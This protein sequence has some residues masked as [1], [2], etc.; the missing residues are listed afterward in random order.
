MARRAAVATAVMTA[1]LA[2]GPVRAAC[3]TAPE[4]AAAQVRDMQSRLMVATLRCRAGGLDVTA[5]YN[6]F[7]QA[8]RSRLEGANMTLKAHFWVDGP[9]E[10]QRAYDRFTTALANAYGAGDTGAESCAEAAAQA[11][12]AAALEGGPEV[13]EAFAA[14]HAGPPALDA[15]GAGNAVIAAR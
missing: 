10:G 14:R 12:E 11:T 5:A 2:A 7:V 9:V 13:L 1:M 4:L 15:C 3:W 8:N 6:A